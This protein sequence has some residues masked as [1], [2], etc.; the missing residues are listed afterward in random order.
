[1]DSDRQKHILHVIVCIYQKMQTCNTGIEESQFTSWLILAFP[2]KP[3]SH[4]SDYSHYLLLWSILKYREVVL[5]SSTHATVQKKT[6]PWNLMCAYR[7]FIFNQ[8]AQSQKTMFRV[9]QTN[10]S[11]SCPLQHGLV[12]HWKCSLDHMSICIQVRAPSLLIWM[13]MQETST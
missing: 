11:P 12:T 6:T 4:Y 2:R 3:S 13:D 8:R 5:E 1:M 7:L 9:P 10:F